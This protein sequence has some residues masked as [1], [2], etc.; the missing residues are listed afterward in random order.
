MT[1][2]QT[3]VPDVKYY[4]A[5][6]DLN[7]IRFVREMNGV[8]E[9][10]YT[11]IPALDFIDP[12][13]ISFKYESGL[14]KGGWLYDVIKP[15]DADVLDS[16]YLGNPLFTQEIN[17]ISSRLFTG[18]N[19]DVLRKLFYRHKEILLKEEGIV[20]DPDFTHDIIG[21]IVKEIGAP[22]MV[23][24]KPQQDVVDLVTN[25]TFPVPSLQSPIAYSLFKEYATTN[26]DLIQTDFIHED[27]TY[28]VSLI[29]V[30]DKVMGYYLSKLDSKTN[31]EESRFTMLHCTNLPTGLYHLFNPEYHI[32]SKVEIFNT[33]FMDSVFD[34]DNTNL[35]AFVDEQVLKYLITTTEEVLDLVPISD[36]KL[37]VSARARPGEIVAVDFDT[38]NYYANNYFL[39]EAT[40]F[41]FI[42][43]KTGMN[44]NLKLTDFI[45][46]I[47]K[48]STDIYAI[49]PVEDTMDNCVE[50]KY[51][52]STESLINQNATSI[53][54]RYLDKIRQTTS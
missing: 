16:V 46:I 30:T 50:I 29:K 15:V 48:V 4:F 43:T 27:I 3:V 6:Y 33:L 54:K 47:R 9:V 31:E 35:S 13:Q 1:T 45:Q 21:L 41:H 24:Y 18:T 10:L 38:F 19:N 52:L 8:A 53:L 14:D 34:V 12:T 23:E 26:K 17:R 7:F 28:F 37:L 22:Y 25:S 32:D 11:F 51:N 49:S 2:T 5:I 20:Q 40:T 42:A 36:D 44:A 39:N